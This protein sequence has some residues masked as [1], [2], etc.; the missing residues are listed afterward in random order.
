ML[1]FDLQYIHRLCFVVIFAFIYCTNATAS[2]LSKHHYFLITGVLLDGDFYV[3]DPGYQLFI[4]RSSLWL[5]FFNAYHDG[6]TNDR[7]TFVVYQSH[8][9]TVR[10]IVLL[11]KRWT[12]VMCLATA[13]GHQQ[14]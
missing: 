2:R 13:H 5:A 9:C 4:I 1:C 7:I 10:L 11:L 8:C 6:A 12:V 3:F 14:K